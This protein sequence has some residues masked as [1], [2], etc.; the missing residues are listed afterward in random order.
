MKTREGAR[1]LRF[2]S[3]Y[4]VDASVGLRAELDDLLGPAAMAA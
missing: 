4:R 2:G 3:D 1:R